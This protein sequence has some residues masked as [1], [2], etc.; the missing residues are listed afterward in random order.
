MSMCFGSVIALTHSEPKNFRTATEL[1]QKSDFESFILGETKMTCRSQNLTVV[2]PFQA[3]R[4]QFSK[5][6]GMPTEANQG[7]RLT[8]SDTEV[9]LQIDLP[10][11]ELA[12][13]AITIHNGILS[14]TGARPQHSPSGGKPLF[15]AARRGDFH[16]TFRLHKFLDTQAVDAVMELGVLTV[17]IP[18]RPEV[19]PQSVQIRS[20]AAS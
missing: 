9:V 12:N 16:H 1:L 3:V 14:I 20:A 8:E 17:S 4:S 11:V 19:L 7:S 13:V 18:K 6:F 15:A 10:G 2:D 5:Q